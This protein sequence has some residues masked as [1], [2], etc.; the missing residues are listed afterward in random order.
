MK[1]TRR[2]LLA[3]SAQ[4]AAAL[5]GLGLWP[6]A[7][8]AQ[9]GAYNGAAFAAK[10]MPDVLKALGAKLPVESPEVTIVAQE[11]AEN[12]AAV[13]ITIGTTLPGAKRLLLLVEK[14]PAL[15]SA[16]LDLTEAIEPQFLLRV[17]M[18]ESSPVIAVALTGDGKAF[19]ARR[20]VAVTLGGC[21]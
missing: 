3:T 19:Y 10:A 21:G 9:A 12:G 20:N 16:I 17:K 14:N 5:A 8:M 1:Q 18:A 13:P 15:L 2:T 6:H 4:V 11:I 7:A